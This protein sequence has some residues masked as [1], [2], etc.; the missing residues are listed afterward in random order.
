MPYF[1][2]AGARLY[3]EERG[4][5]EALVFLHGASLDLHQWDRQM[6]HFAADYHVIA[7]DARGHGRSTLPPGAVR[8]EQFWQDVRALLDHL[9]IEK[10]VLCG[11]S[12]G[13]HTALQTAIYAPERVRALVL[14]GT[15]CTNRFNLYEKICVPINR[16]CIRCMPMKWVA[17]CLAVSL[18]GDAASRAYIL[19]TVGAMDHDVFDRVWKAV[20]TMESRDG[21]ARVACPAL[22]LIGDR[23]K[24]TGRQ[25]ETLHT[26]IRGSQL[27]TIAHANHGTNLDNPEQVETEMERFLSA[28]RDAARRQTRG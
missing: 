17:W 13:G 22:I 5:G 3:Y 8:P 25:Q 21:L 11:L 26:G 27:V 15:P 14:I 23:D 4:C 10:A 24:L 2:N 1:E 18:G 28:C 19:R 16:A 20:T 9:G 12:M 6:E 7:M